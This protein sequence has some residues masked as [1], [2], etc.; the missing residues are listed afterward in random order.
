MDNALERYLFARAD[1]T[2]VPLK[3]TL[4]LTPLCNLACRMCYLR[5]EPG[6][7]RDKG[8]LLPPDFWRGLIPAL[9]EAGT[10]F[11]ALI[12][13]EIFTLPWLEELYTELHRSGFYLNFTT[14]GVLLADGVP[15][16]LISH[17][18]RYTTVSLYG[19]T[20]ETYRRLT[21]AE[22]GFT[23]TVAG[24]ENLLCA[25]IPTKLNALIGPENVGELAEIARFAKERELPLL[26]TAYQFP[27]GVRNTCTGYRR[28]EPEAAA[29][30]ELEL[31]R[32]TRNPQA[33]ADWLAWMQS[34]PFPEPERGR[35]FRCRAA[36]STVWISWRGRLS[37]CGML[38]EPSVDLR[39]GTPFPE[40]LR[41]LREQTAAVTLSEDCATCAKHSHCSVCP[42]MLYTESGSF[43]RVPHYLC[44]FTKELI[45]LASE[46]PIPEGL[47]GNP[48]TIRNE[49]AEELC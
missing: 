46:E 14:N 17:K 25:G 10:L 4:E 13:G 8:G 2:G 24:I 19:T 43:D 29:R 48:E 26:A 45:R 36:G 6:E 28:L 18:P 16:W 35:R 42:A 47:T 41:R 21:G 20:D 12:G 44:R 32:L 34:P 27:N 39:D 38:E 33:F 3:A 40:A 31:R 37:A 49:G 7:V 15:D 9:R 22:H 30:A 5:H 11:V 23:R 1:R